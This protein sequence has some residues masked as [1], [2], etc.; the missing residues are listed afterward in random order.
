MG[1]TQTGGSEGTPRSRDRKDESWAGISG[2][3]YDETEGPD[4]GFELSPR[5][6]FE[7]RVFGHPLPSSPHEPA[8]DWFATHLEVEMGRISWN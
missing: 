5:E 3:V 2:M 7:I 8:P 1:Q 6:V 4:N